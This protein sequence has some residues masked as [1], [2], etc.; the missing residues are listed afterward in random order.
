MLSL[1]TRPRDKHYDVFLIAT[2]GLPE[3]LFYVGASR[4]RTREN[5]HIFTKDSALCIKADQE[6]LEE[7]RRLRISIGKSPLPDIGSPLSPINHT[8]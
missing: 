2:P 4:V 1:I 8:Q 6:A 5:L 7:Y 3:A